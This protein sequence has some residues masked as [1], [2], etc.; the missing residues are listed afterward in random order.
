MRTSTAILV[1]LLFIAPCWAQDESLLYIIE[2]KNGGYTLLGGA[3][4]GCTDRIAELEREVADLRARLDLV[5][6]RTWKATVTPMPGPPCNGATIPTIECIGG[7]TLV[8]VDH[9]WTCSSIWR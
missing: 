4:G 1:L 3:L 6:G 2:D 8:C 9:R 7:S 5:Q